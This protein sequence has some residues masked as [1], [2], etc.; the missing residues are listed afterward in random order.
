MIDDDERGKIESKA[1]W[2][3]GVENDIRGLKSDIK[4]AKGAALA[5]LAAVGSKLLEYLSARLWP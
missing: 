2:E 4:F 1:R 5:G 3:A